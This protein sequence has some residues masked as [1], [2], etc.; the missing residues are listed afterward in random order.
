MKLKLIS[1][2]FSDE[3]QTYLYLYPSEQMIKILS[4]TCSSQNSNGNLLD[5]LPFQGVKMPAKH[6]V[7]CLKMHSV[8]HYL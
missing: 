2:E 6:L 3:L 7:L 5:N 8:D 4:M 1:A